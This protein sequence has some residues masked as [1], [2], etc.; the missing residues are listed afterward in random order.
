[1]CVCVCVCV[2]MF[3]ML[4]RASFE[5]N[6]LVPRVQKIKIRKLGLIEF[7]RLNFVKEIWHTQLWALETNGLKMSVLD[8][9]NTCFL[10][11][12]YIEVQKYL[13]GINGLI[14]RLQSLFADRSAAT[15]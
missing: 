4:T 8:P 2:W 6:P 11:L 5:F 3:E 10:N 9:C 1:M 13:F 12:N 7:Y 14:N 15:S